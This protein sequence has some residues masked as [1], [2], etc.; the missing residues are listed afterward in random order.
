M[1]QQKKRR[2]SGRKLNFTSWDNYII[3]N[4]RERERERVFTKEGVA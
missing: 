2:S 1:F 4:L 3:E